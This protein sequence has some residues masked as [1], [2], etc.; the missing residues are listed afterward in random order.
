MFRKFWKP[1]NTEAKILNTAG[2]GP[3]NKKSILKPNKHVIF[4]FPLRINTIKVTFSLGTD[5]FA[6]DDLA[7]D[8]TLSD[9]LC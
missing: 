6:Y 9:V 5:M 4:P 3:K 7:N 8:Y 1:G 2:N